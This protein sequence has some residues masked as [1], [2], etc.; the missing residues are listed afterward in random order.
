M[1]RQRARE[2]TGKKGKEKDE[3]EKESIKKDKAL[4]FYS[5]LAP[6]VI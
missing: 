5:F 3:D 4:N 6:N 1:E 2:K